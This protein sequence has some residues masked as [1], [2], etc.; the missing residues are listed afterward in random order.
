VSYRAIF[1]DDKFNGSKMMKCNKCGQDN[2]AEAK[3]CSACGSSMADVVNSSVNNPTDTP[4][5]ANAQPVVPMAS[6]SS[7]NFNNLNATAQT[8]RNPAHIVLAIECIFGILFVTA[9]VGLVIWL[10]TSK[11]KAEVLSCKQETAAV[12]ESYAYTFEGDKMS[13]AEITYI[14]DKT[15]EDDESAFGVAMM[16]AMKDDLEKEYGSV[17]GVDLKIDD[18]RTIAVISYVLDLNKVEG[19]VKKEILDDI[20]G[21][22]LEDLKKEGQADGYTCTVKGD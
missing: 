22:S 17:P 5:S 15:I 16:V 11:N 3:F 13:K 7:G 20:D 1:K 19:D 18:S 21:K 8:K 6:I 2:A 10:M 9:M 4:M 14:W 12:T